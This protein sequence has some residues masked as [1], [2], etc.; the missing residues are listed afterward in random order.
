MLPVIS[1]TALNSL[2]DAAI[3]IQSELLNRTGE[4]FELVDLNGVLA[5]WLEMSIESLAEDAVYHCVEGDCSYAFNQDGF[6]RLLKKV[7][8]KVKQSA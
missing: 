1:C 5:Q 8:S 4:E 2:N 7:P 3:R 6:N